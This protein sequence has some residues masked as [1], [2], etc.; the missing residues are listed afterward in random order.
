MRLWRAGLT[1][2]MAGILTISV[3]AAG[4]ALV[5]SFD[6]PV[7]TCPIGGVSAPYTIATTAGDAATVV[8][9][10]TLN[11]AVVASKQYVVASGNVS[12]GGGW[13]FAG[14]TKTR[15]GVFTTSGLV[16]GTY[17][18]E[19]CA[20]QAGSA[21]NPNKKTCAVETIVVNCDL[22][23]TTPCTEAPFGEVVGN[24]H[25]GSHAA[26]ELQFRGDFGPS[27]LVTVAGPGFSDSASINQNGNSCTY[28]ANW[29]FQNANGSDLSGDGGPGSYLVTVTGNGH[30][31]TFLVDLVN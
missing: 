17:Q 18:L 10:L 20:T 12:T 29:K 5:V 27:A 11:E 28:H 19:V 9:T 31:L 21:G 8:E 22:V 25:I 15:D 26:A 16:N 2:A 30:T 3:I 24:T 13:L 1:I 14:R 4:T 6:T 23:L 7:V